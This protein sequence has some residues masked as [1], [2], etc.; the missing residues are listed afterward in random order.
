MGEKV[1]K[2][3]ARWDEAGRVWWADSDDIPG[4]VTEA[5]SFDALVERITQI[6]PEIIELNRVVPAG[7]DVVIA[8]TGARETRLKVAA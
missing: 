2:V 4:L 6:A 3:V 8:V 5:P 7:T 1:L